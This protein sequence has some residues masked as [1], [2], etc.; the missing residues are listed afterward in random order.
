MTNEERLEKLSETGKKSIAKLK[1]EGKIITSSE[2][3]RELQKLSAQSKRN[4]KLRRERSMQDIARWLGQLT[5]SKDLLYSPDEIQDMEKAKAINLTANEAILLAQYQKAITG[6]TKAA[7]FIRDT[8][9]EKP[10]EQIE[11]QG[12]TIDEY[13]QNHKPKF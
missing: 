13:A 10:K 9:G 8:A 4:A 6:D 11:V 5:L 1:A 12:M 3:A 7:E 2:R